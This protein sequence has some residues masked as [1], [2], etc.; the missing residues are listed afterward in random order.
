MPTTLRKLCTL[1]IASVLLS[2]ANKEDT[3]ILPDDCQL[4]VG[5]VV[6]R[7]GGGIT[8]HAVLFSDRHGHYS[9]V[10]IVVD[11]AGQRMIVH[12]VPGEPDFPG[13]PDRVKM[14]RPDRFF[15]ALRAQAGEVC[16]TDCLQAAQTAARKALELYRRHTPF[17]HDY[18]DRD[19]T[20]MYC[21]ELVDFVYRQARMPL[22]NGQHHR[23]DLPGLHADC[24][25]PSDIY[26]CAHL[27]S[28]ITF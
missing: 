19:T 23:V 28:V 21:T 2:C 10:G 20:R 15:S 4:K 1:A 27:K 8:S 22:T 11:S 6:F 25:F 5:D 24:I 13:D 3:S 26:R 7:R 18:N 9:H 12:A 14:E 16:R 17:D